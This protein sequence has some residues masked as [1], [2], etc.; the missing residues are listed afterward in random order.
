MATYLRQS[1][2]ENSGIR[3]DRTPDYLGQF[4]GLCL[5]LLLTVGVAANESQASLLAQS[6]E[7]L[8]VTE[9][10][11]AQIT[12]EYQQLLA[13]GTLAE[14]EIEEYQ[15]FLTRLSALVAQYHM[16]IAVVTGTHKAQPS[17]EQQAE[18]LSKSLSSERTVEEQAKSFDDEL[19]DLLGDFDGML[20][21]EQEEL[22]TR[23]QTTEA[24]AAGGQELATGGS[25]GEATDASELG[26]QDPSKT[27]RSDQGESGSGSS[28]KPERAPGSG[29]QVATGGG[30]NGS[31]TE[32]R[33]LNEPAN[34]PSGADDD[35]VARQLREAAQRET[36]PQL[37]K[38]LWEEYKLYKQA[39]P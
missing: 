5:G 30:Y 33:V 39:S 11:L 24:A 32:A 12:A 34:I 31:S 16:E 21:R 8:R 15:S 22:A 38:R 13:G 2:R 7:N 20:L 37:Q 3:I 35:I 1:H 23:S 25:A 28:E 36:D 9:Q 18:A 27:E 29:S 6:Q 17:E 19:R 10:T 4:V 26:A 14:K